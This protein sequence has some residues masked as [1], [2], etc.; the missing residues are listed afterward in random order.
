MSLD[1]YIAGPGDDLSFLDLVSMEGEDYGYSEF[2][3]SV[4]T[5]VM[6]RRTYDKILEITR[7]FPH[8]DKE[9]YILTRTPRPASGNIMFYSESPED[10]IAKLKTTP[11]KNIFI[12]GGSETANVLMRKHCIDEFIISVIPVLLGEGIPLFKE[13]GAVE[14]MRF[15]G[16]K[17]FPTGLVQLHYSRK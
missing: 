4:S 11:G 2:M 14:Q 7:E 15:E 17:S 8:R 10:L 1:G 6:G 13:G 12:D 9:T 16:V 3:E 5:V